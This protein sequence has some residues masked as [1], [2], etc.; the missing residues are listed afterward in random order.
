MLRNH[1]LIL[2]NTKN[3]HA[4]VYSAIYKIILINCGKICII[5]GGKMDTSSEV[6][7]VELDEEL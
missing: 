4:A 7:G 2:V 3:F 6:I 5:C 1:V